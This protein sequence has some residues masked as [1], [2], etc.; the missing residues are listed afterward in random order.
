MILQAIQWPQPRHTEDS[1]DNDAKDIQP[2]KL[3]LVTGFFRT[4][5]EHGNLFV[6]LDGTT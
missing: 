1:D 5:V 6:L 2:E 4:F 3:N